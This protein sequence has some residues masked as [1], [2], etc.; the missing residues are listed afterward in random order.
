VIAGAT[1]TATLTLDFPP[2]GS[3][4][5][6]TL[7]SSSP[8]AVTFVNVTNN[9]VTVPP[10]RV[11]AAFQIKTNAVTS[12]TDVLISATL[13]S[14]TRQARL[15]VQVVAVTISPPSLSTFTGRSQ[16]FSATVSG[17]VSD[18]SVAWSILEPNGGSV[19]GTGLYVAPAGPGTFHVVATSVA[20]RNKTATATVQVANKPKEKEK[21]KDKD[22]EKEGKE[23]ERIN[24][25]LI[26]R[27][28]VEPIRR[29]DIDPVREQLIDAEGRSFILVNE[30]PVIKP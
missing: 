5:N 7:S 20:D 3:G 11:Q 21:D 2:T 4:A 27:E 8:S 30:R 18:T 10:G 26:A 24:D 19:N 13:G 25:K 29:F 12:T 17:G 15:S 28:L 1:V 16:Q 6:I 14:V 23:K 9:T 22:K